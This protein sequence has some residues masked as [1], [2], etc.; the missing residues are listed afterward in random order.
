MEKITTKKELIERLGDVMAVEINA[1]NS[2]IQDIATFKNFKIIDSITKIKEDEDK[3]IK[4][5][6]E[7][8]NMLKEH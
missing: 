1:R 5:L 4:L 3:H 2:Y 6:I 7:L 8:V